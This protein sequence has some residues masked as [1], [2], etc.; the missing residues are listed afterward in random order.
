M[1]CPPPSQRGFGMIEVLVSLVIIAVGL[2]GLASAQVQAQKA[3]LESYQRA[4]AM[5]LVEDMVSRIRANRSADE[6]YETVDFIGHGAEP[7]D[8]SG[9]GTNATRDLAN[10]D[11]NAWD[12]LLEGQAESL[13]DDNAGAMTGARGC[14]SKDTTVTDYDAYTVTVAWQGEVVTEEPSEACASDQYGA[15]GLRR[16]VSTQVAIPEY[17]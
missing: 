16:V 10:S 4:Q 15:D 1:I 9:W 12:D 13:G 17:E 14:I 7:A 2:L 6:C 8:C 11:L 5:M 3:E